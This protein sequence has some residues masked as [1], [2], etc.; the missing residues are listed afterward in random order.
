MT[1]LTQTQQHQSPNSSTH[2]ALSYT[3]DLG[4]LG[5]AVLEKAANQHW[6]LDIKE[7]LI[8]LAPMYR[9]DENKA[10]S[11]VLPL[12]AALCLAQEHTA[13]ADQLQTEVPFLTRIKNSSM[14]RL[15]LSPAMQTNG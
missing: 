15:I 7:T 2:T 1:T 13:T 8:H 12:T 5:H 3:E 4:S 6:Q 11:L 10:L 14:A 9:I